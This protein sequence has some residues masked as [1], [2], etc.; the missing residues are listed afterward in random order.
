MKNYAKYLISLHTCMLGGDNLDLHKATQEEIVE[1]MK[2]DAFKITIVGVGTLGTFVATEFLKADAR[3]IATDIRPDVV[4]AIN[5]RNSGSSDPKIRKILH[6]KV[7]E[8]KLKATTDVAGAAA[9][10]KVICICVPTLL[11]KDQNPDLSQL[12]NAADTVSKGLTKHSI[13]MLYSTVPIGTT[14]NIVLPILQRSG[15]T[16]G[17]FCL[18]YTPER[19]NPG[20]TLGKAARIPRVVSG[21]DERSKNLAVKII[22]ALR[23]KVVPVSSV[24][25]AEAT[26]LF[27]NTFRDVN[28]ALV[29]DLAIHFNRLGLDILEVVKAASTKWNI[30]AHYP[31]AGVGGY[32]IPVS[33]HYLAVRSHPHELRILKVAREI[34]DNMPNYIVDLVVNNLTQQGK[35]I[36]GSKITILGLAYKENL[37]ELRWSPSIQIIEQ[38]K[39][40]GAKVSLHDPYASNV[41]VKKMYG[42]PNLQLEEALKDSDCMVIVTGHEEF[43]KLQFEKIKA[44]MKDRASVIDGRNI[45]N[46]ADVTSNGFIYAGV[47][48]TGR[49][50]RGLVITQQTTLHDIR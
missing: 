12:K 4:E 31:G 5:N 46:S 40:F 9:D 50:E 44:L 43:K 11:S 1:D 33:P 23:R 34:N 32:C 38:L 24:E 14:R 27:E 41:D 49:T 13:V 47:G 2:N 8:G 16:I 20:I 35:P 19:M 17:D 7:S 3:V 42:L 22:K 26:K 15:L 18:A 21:I 28:I 30:V 10:S 25:Q 45:V 48:R 39:T 6:N 36:Q 37:S 29:N